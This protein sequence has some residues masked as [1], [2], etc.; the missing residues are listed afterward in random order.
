MTQS[1]YFAILK[2]KWEQVDKTDR[3]AIHAYNEFKRQ[4]RHQLDEEE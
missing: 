4:L 2:E 1:E 3:E